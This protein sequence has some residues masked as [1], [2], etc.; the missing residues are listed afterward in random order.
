M[1]HSIIAIDTHKRG[2]LDE[3]PYFLFD[4]EGGHIAFASPF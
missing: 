4:K 2:R 3:A 1:Q